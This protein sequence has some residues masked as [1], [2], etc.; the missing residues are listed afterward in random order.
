[1]LPLAAGVAGLLLLAPRAPAQ[2]PTSGPYRAAVVSMPSPYWGY[3]RFGEAAMLH[4]AADVIRA[5]G[6]FIVNYEQA[7]MQR[8]EVR[9]KHMETRRKQME[10]W[11]WERDFRLGALN[12]EQKKFREEQVEFNRLYPSRA[13]VLTGQP[14]NV[15]FDDLQVRQLAAE[16]STPVQEEWLAQ[17]HVTDGGR[18]NIG[19]LKG[20]KITWPRLFLRGSFL[21]QRDKIDD[22]LAQA[23][24]L[25]RS[26]DRDQAEMGAVLDGLEAAVRECEA[27]LDREIKNTV[28]DPDCNP[29]HYIEGRK[30]L[31][32][33]IDATF[34]L[35][36]SEA[37]FYLNPPE[38]KTVADLVGYMKKHGLRFAAATPGTERYYT[39]LHRALADE[40]SRIRNMETP[41]NR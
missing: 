35:Q 15:L 41:T 20:E 4:G 21:E 6:E 11:E 7:R 17:V 9:Q 27:R 2:L 18:A 1:L 8:E 14:L 28:G 24:K 39:A 16:G 37:A 31:K 38:G 5:Q 34:A 10:Q 30:F 3:W 36:G 19:L 26:R 32:S 40:V 13:E 12:R 25:A 22:L 29:R 23:K 33:V